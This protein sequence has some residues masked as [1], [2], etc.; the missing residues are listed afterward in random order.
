M[1]WVALPCAR[2]NRLRDDYFNELIAA[3]NERNA[4]TL[5]AAALVDVVV[6]KRARAIHW[7][8]IRTRIEALIPR[9]ANP[10]TGA[11]WTKA[12]CLQAAIGHPDW[13]TPTIQGGMRP[14]AIWFNEMKLV[15]DKLYV[16]GILGDGEVWYRSPKS[17][18]GLTWDLAW[19]NARAA[20]WGSSWI[21][22]FDLVAQAGL[23]TLST[24]AGGKFKEFVHLRMPSLHF[25]VPAFVVPIAS[26]GV[27]FYS[28]GAVVAPLV[29]EYYTQADFA[30]SPILFTWSG[31]A[32]PAVSIPIPGTGG[33][34]Y[35]GVRTQDDKFALDV[36]DAYEPADVH[37]ATTGAQLTAPRLVLALDFEYLV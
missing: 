23:R 3:C 20:Y 16:I 14:R 33:R 21:P 37:L 24:D 28:V 8:T 12:T 29:F 22:G 27:I 5:K 25:D 35:H 19:A 31:S 11:A 6:G 4:E 17:G 1:G 36:V 9:F 10:D 13:T 30:G 26:A 2:D 34:I 32:A 18:T 7:T 15:L